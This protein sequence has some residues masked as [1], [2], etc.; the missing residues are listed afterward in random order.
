MVTVG[1][2]LAA[3]ASSRI[4]TA[5]AGACWAAGL[6]PAG[7]CRRLGLAR[8]EV[9]ARMGVTQG[10]VFAIAYARPGATELRTLA[11]RAGAAPAAG[12]R[13]SPTCLAE[14]GTEAA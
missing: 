2:I 9:A 6:A 12:W 11:A 10:G 4:N 13:S 3:L 8:A 7:T 14:P 5:R 1:D